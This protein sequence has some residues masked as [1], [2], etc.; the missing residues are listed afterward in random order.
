MH[1]KYLGVMLWPLLLP[2]VV[3]A[4]SRTW[5]NVRWV[6]DGDTV[7]LNDNRSLRY[8]G[9]N[10]PEIDYQQH[11]AEPFAYAARRLNRKLVDGT[12][13]RLEFE[14]RKTDR[15]GRLLAYVFLKDNTLV[16]RE[17]L[18]HG[19]GYFYPSSHPGKYD[20]ILLKAQ[21]DAMASKKGLWRDWKEPDGTATFVANRRS[22]RFHLSSCPNG[23]KISRKN[24]IYFKTMW[25]AYWEGYAPAKG[26]MVNKKKSWMS[27]IKNL[28]SNANSK[29]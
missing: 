8:L 6:N 22:K 21:Q 4:N 12:P 24:R 7:I 3:Q 17:L 16:N 23:K 28:F 25:K 20:D 29:I 11:R 18:R 13:I 27:R 9:I 26:C 19:Y 1:F 5:H 14:K 2:L 10:T 15:F